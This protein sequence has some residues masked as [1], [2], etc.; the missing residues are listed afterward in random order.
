MVDAPAGV[1]GGLGAGDDAVGGVLLV[2][3]IFLRLVAP[4]MPSE[5]PTTMLNSAKAGSLPPVSVVVPAPATTPPTMP[6]MNLRD[7]VV[8]CFIASAAIVPVAPAIAQGMH[9]ARIVGGVIVAPSFCGCFHLALLFAVFRQHCKMVGHG[10]VAEGC[11]SGCASPERRGKPETASQ[12]PG[13]VF[14]RPHGLLLLLLLLL[15]RE[16]H[17]LQSLDDSLGGRQ[18]AIVTQRAFVAERSQTTERKRIAQ[19]SAP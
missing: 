13:Q 5:A 11:L 15:H 19:G 4:K 7:T 17:W 18:L 9:T 6:P 8:G 12:R 1:A 2:E 3:V 16:C 10:A 14:G